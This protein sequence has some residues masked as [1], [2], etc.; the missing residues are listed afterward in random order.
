MCHR[1]VWCPPKK[2]GGQLDDS[3]AVAQKL[4]D[5]PL[6]YLVY[7]QTEGN[8]GLPNG[9]STTPRPV[10]AIKGTPRCMEQHTKQTLST[11]KFRDSATTP[12]KCLRDI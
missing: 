2:E 7:P 5:V 11:L 9:T 10:G 8:Q 4:T 3:V 1:T 12:S 6:D